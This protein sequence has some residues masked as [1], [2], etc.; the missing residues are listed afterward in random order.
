MEEQILSSISSTTN[1]LEKTT[2]Y[3]LLFLVTTTLSGVKKSEKIKILGFEVRRNVSTIVLYGTLCGLMFS[4][5]RLL[6]NISY[7]LSQ[8]ENS[9][10]IEK[11]ILLLQTH[12][13][14]L[15]PFSQTSG[16]LAFLFDHLGCSFLLTMSYF[17]SALGSF[18]ILKIKKFKAS[19]LITTGVLVALY[20]T[21]L[22]I[23]QRLLISLIK[24]V[25]PE[26]AVIK[27]V[28]GLLFAAISIIALLPALNK[29]FNLSNDTNCSP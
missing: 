27:I 16:S 21:L 7:L 3:F 8:L 12:P 23:E 13:W 29:I 1:A 4:L 11:A 14:V 19:T 22:I 17:G 26:T 25:A 28:S 15:N 24:E 10:N 6:L 9:Q 18:F 5:I 20:T 2:S